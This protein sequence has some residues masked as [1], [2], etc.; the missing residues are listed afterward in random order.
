MSPFRPQR[1]GRIDP[2]TA[3]GGPERREKAHDGHQRHD[4]RQDDDGVALHEVTLCGPLEQRRRDHTKN[5]PGRELPQ[6]T[7][8]DAGE[9]TARVSA[10]CR[11]NTNLSSTLRDGER[12]HRVNSGRREENDAQRHECKS[13][14]DQTRYSLFVAKHLVHHEDVAQLK[15]WVDGRGDLP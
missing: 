3:P 7:R 10:Q 2:Q 15:V 5:S 9:K 13:C 14:G 6:R 11:P 1:F 12:H 8:E 4:D